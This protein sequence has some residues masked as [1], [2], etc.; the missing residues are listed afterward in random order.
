MHY[1]L[2]FESIQFT[3]P[4]KSIQIV[5]STWLSQNPLTY[6]LGLQCDQ[7]IKILKIIVH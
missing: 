7:L 4:N 1:N 6:K 3:S 2:Y 5:N